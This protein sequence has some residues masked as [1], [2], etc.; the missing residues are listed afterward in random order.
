MGSPWRIKFR[1]HVK[2]GSLGR[3]SCKCYTRAKR[4]P[5]WVG[6]YMGLFYGGKK[7][8]VFMTDHTSS[9]ESIGKLESKNIRYIQ[10]P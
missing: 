8:M 5:E 1:A 2:G 7:T 10:T 6:T 9:E 4:G 3:S